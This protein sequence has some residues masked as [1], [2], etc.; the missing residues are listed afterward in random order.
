MLIGYFNDMEKVIGE[1]KR[2][3]APGAR[4]AMVVDNVGLSS[5]P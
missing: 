1:W 2:I 3:L 4:V 5:F